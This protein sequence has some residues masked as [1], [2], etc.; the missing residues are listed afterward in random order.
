M[1][2]I[3][4]HR[5]NVVKFA[6]LRSLC[7]FLNWRSGFHDS[8]LISEVQGSGFT[9]CGSGLKVHWDLERVEGGLDGALFEAILGNLLHRRQNR[10]LDLSPITET[11]ARQPTADLEPLMPDAEPKA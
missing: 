4:V 3:D 11:T 10:R 7:G 2:T 8:E 5:Y 9:V 6:G 1:M